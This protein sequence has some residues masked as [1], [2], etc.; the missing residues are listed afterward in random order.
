MAK[1]RAGLATQKQFDDRPEDPGVMSTAFSSLLHPLDT[2]TGMAEQ[3]SPLVF[4]AEAPLFGA[5]MRL[6]VQPALD[7]AAQEASEGAPGMAGDLLSVL[8]RTPVLGRTV[9]YNEALSAGQP[10]RAVGELLGGVVDYSLMRDPLMK[11]PRSAFGERFPDAASKIGRTVDRVKTAVTPTADSMMM[12][13]NA[14]MSALENNRNLP[15]G[16]PLSAKVAKM[17][18]D[19]TRKPR[20]SAQAWAARQLAGPPEPVTME[21]PPG[22]VRTG[23]ATPGI[24]PSDLA[25]EWSVRPPTPL[26]PWRWDPEHSG[27]P[28]VREQYQGRIPAEVSPVRE[29]YPAG[30]QLNPERMIP[31]SV[32]GQ[33]MLPPGPVGRPM[34]GEVAP[35]PVIDPNMGSS[36]TGSDAARGV[37]RDPSTGR[38]ARVYTSD[39]LTDPAKIEQLKVERLKAIML[40]KKAAK[41]GKPV[42]KAPPPEPVVTPAKLPPDVTHIGTQKGMKGEPLFETYNVKRPD[43]GSDTFAVKPGESVEAKAAA[44]RAA[45]KPRASGPS[46]EEA[47]LDMWRKSVEALN[48]KKKLAD[49]AVGTTRAEMAM[50]QEEYQPPEM[51]RPRG[52][53]HDP[54][55]AELKV[56]RELLDLLK[57]PPMKMPPKK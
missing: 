18:L 33:K 48:N 5:P 16:T 45:Q 55:E 30:Q 43:G 46:A 13:S 19:Q 11:G 7:S 21:I 1:I 42:V 38:G 4:S 57:M 32:P 6:N 47:N 35:A 2:M 8:K 53:G 31:S 27:L 26:E 9:A 44:V 28:A 49:S 41:A 51:R 20:A 25:K 50:E 56:S 14:N 22:A 12:R 29:G 54:S 15:M 34:P 40:E 17:V 24:M 23:G 10:N 52:M 39:P 3:L 37:Y 36:V